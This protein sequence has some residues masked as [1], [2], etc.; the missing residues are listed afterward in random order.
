MRGN[1]LENISASDVGKIRVVSVD[2]ESR[3]AYLSEFSSLDN[4]VDGSVNGS[5]RGVNT[6]PEGGD[7]TM[8]L[9]AFAEGT[10]TKASGYASHA[11]G[12]GS[13]ASGGLAHAEGT[14]KAIGNH[15]HSEGSGTITNGKSQHVCGEF[16]VADPS[17]NINPDEKGEYVFIAGNGT[18][19]NARSNAFAIKWD[20]T[21]VFANGE[22]LTPAKVSQLLAL[23]S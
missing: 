19:D 11:E 22:E 5:I 23:L 8:G 2:G 4:L 16:N 1:Q 18:A 3:N 20:G 13:L 17:G 12:G 14:S 21:L 15:S 9:S 6:V 10:G 7:Y